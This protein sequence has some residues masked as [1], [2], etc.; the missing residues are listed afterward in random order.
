MFRGALP[1]E[2]YAELGEQFEEIEHQ[3]FDEDGFD[4]AVQQV[5]GIERRLKLSDLASF[6][7]PPVG[8]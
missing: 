7:E 4:H 6:T 1:D 5:A 2:R 3:E 8:A